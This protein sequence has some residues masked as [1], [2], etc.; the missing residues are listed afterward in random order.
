MSE[1]ANRLKSKETAKEEDLLPEIDDLIRK[2]EQDIRFRTA[3]IRGI[4]DDLKTL[5]DEIDSP[6]K[7]G[8]GQ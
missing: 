7:K 6:A 3:T 8:P 1:R 5:A 2:N 4:V